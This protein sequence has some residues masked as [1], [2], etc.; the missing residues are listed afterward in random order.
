M[1]STICSRIPHPRG[2]LLSRPA[3]ENRV[4]DDRHAI[5]GGRTAE[6]RC[7]SLSI[8]RIELLGDQPFNE[9]AFHLH[10]TLLESLL[11]TRLDALPPTVFDAPASTSFE[12]LVEPLF[13][14][15]RHP[16]SPSPTGFRV[17]FQDV[18]QGC[19]DRQ[20]VC[21]VRFV[22]THGEHDEIDAS[23]SR[24]PG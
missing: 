13:I 18:G 22:G 6:D 23:Q 4:A 10:P 11:H 3:V 17:R 24:S 19:L 15:Q 8:A 14:D 20:L 12:S 9:S 16:L 21:F 7:K 2:D 1:P 5:R